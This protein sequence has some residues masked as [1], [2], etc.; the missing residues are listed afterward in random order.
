MITP[1]GHFVLVKVIK[2]ER[3]SKG[4]IVI[5]HDNHAIADRAQQQGVIVAIGPQA[6]QANLDYD[7][8][9]G[10]HRGQPWAE[11]NDIIV[12]PQYAPAFIEDKFTGEEYALIKDEDV[13]AI[14][15]DG[16][17]AEVTIPEFAMQVGESNE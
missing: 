15:K 16:K 17:N 13:K 6:W 7:Q 12:F 3:K 10:R 14:M 8:E 4:G 1:T 5:A 11:V 9:G 2:A